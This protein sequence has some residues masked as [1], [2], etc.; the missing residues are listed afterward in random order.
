MRWGL[1]SWPPW[2]KFLPSSTQLTSKLALLIASSTQIN[3]RM[4]IFDS[5]SQLWLHYVIKNATPSQMLLL[6]CPSIYFIDFYIQTLHCSS[7]IAFSQCPCTDTVM[8][9]DCVAIWIVFFFSFDDHFSSTPPGTEDPKK[10]IFNYCVLKWK[11][12]IWCKQIPIWQM[13]LHRLEIEM[14]VFLPLEIV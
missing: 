7:F 13:K 12:L 4:S 1:P 10:T 3:T 6:H 9:S 8:S 11:K 5:P 14:Y 2:I